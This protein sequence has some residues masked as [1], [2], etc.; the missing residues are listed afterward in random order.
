MVAQDIHLELLWRVELKAVWCL[1]HEIAIAP[2]IY[3]HEVLSEVVGQKALCHLALAAGLDGLAEV[4]LQELQ[5]AVVVVVVEGE[6]E[7]VV[8]P[9]T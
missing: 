7:E 4:R 8:G 2:E 9:R 1:L 5:P 3:P 6:L